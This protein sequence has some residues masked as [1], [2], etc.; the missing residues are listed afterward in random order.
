MKKLINGCSY[1]ELWV[2]PANWKSLTSSKSLSKVWYV[3]CK[4]YDPNYEH[5]YP[6]GFLYK[7]RLNRFKN[8]SERKAAVSIFKTEMKKALDDGY[9]PIT[10]QYTFL[11][12]Y[13]ALHSEVGLCDALQI[14]FE[15]KQLAEPTEIDIKSVLKY[16]KKSAIALGIDKKS[17]KEVK[18]SEIKS[19]LN[20]L[21]HINPKF[22]DKRYNK[23]IR[24][25]SGLFSDLE[26]LEIIDFNPMVRMKPKK[27]VQ[28]LKVVL[29]DRQR[30]MIKNHIKKHHFNF[31]IFINIYFHAGCRL[32]E[33]R[34]LRV[35]DVNLDNQ[36]FVILV[37][38]GKNYVEKVYPIKNIAM[39]YWMH[40]LSGPHKPSDYVFQWNY[41]P[42]PKRMDR[43]TPS[44]KWK[45]VV[46]DELNIKVDLSSLRHLNL[47]E[48]TMKR[49][50]SAAAV[51][52]GHTSTLM[53]QKH[54][55]VRERE[56]QV[57]NLKSMDNEF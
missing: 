14:A 16:F 55:A 57:E 45:R 12:V 36:T 1:S 31:W 53:V 11:G 21:Y 56:R 2:S 46:K 38:K 33:I 40:L 9:N 25:L 51:A 52:G 37:K 47:D 49:S 15:N 30:E 18:R 44:N 17:V 24:Y 34:N 23:Y 19:I 35:S 20:N 54:Y 32:T 28:K 41:L 26:E 48:I 13:E 29:N 22:T 42:G 5:Q 4:F 39:K 6:N 43:S 7:R 8:L 10:G 3:A 27:T 50:L